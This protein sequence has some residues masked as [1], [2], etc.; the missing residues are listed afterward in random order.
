MADL[1][2][3]PPEPAPP[4]PP[5]EPA[6]DA[7]SQALSEALR[8]SFAIVKFVMV[9]LVFVFLGSGLFTVREGERAI[10]LRLGKPVGEGEKQLLGPGLHWSL[11]YP[12]EEY[13]KIPITE[14]QSVTSTIGWYNVTPEQELAGTEPFPTASLNPVSEGYL[15]TA[16]ANIV[17]SRATVQYRIA[18]PIGY[19]FDFVNASNAVQNALDNALLWTAARFTVDEILT[20]DVIGFTEAVRKRLNQLIEEQALGVVV[21]QCTVRSLPPRYLKDAFAGVLRAEVNRNKTLDEA[22][23][24]ENQVLS[25]ASADAQ[26]RIDAAESDRARLVA[27]VSSRAEQFLELLPKFRQNPELFVQQRLTETLGRVLTNAQDTIF[28]SETAAGKSRELRLLLNREPPK[29]KLEQPK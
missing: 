6:L 1:H 25:R 19:V 20:R 27:E 15:L 8:S 18:N 3:H 21:E 10:K 17:H 7:G 22:R 5:V 28:L 24:Y 14:I 9:V 13:Q 11:P 2:S 4:E 12:I 23:S 29:P 16:D 26:S